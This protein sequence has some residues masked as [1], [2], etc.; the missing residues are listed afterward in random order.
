MIIDKDDYD[1]IS[2]IRWYKD[3]NGYVRGNGSAGTFKSVLLHQLILDRVGVKDGM[4][5]DHINGNKLDNR[6]CNLRIV[7]RIQN[8]RNKDVIKTNTSGYT[9]VSYNKERNAWDSYITVNY[10]KI[11]L[12]RYKYKDEAIKARKEAE[13]KYFGEYKYKGDN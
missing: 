4:E 12:G 2:K 3:S 1:K 7:N 9:G 10:K 8:S 11:N 13:E 6:K 5:I